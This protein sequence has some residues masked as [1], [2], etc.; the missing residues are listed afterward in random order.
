M[1]RWDVYEFLKDA[2]R[3]GHKIPSDFAYAV[4]AYSMPRSEIEEGI[5]EFELMRE[6]EGS[7]ATG[8]VRGETDK[9]IVV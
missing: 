6:R 9:R 7:H 2:Y 1:N 4:F 3:K 5:A 8:G